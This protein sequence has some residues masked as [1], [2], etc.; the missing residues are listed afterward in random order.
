MF[1]KNTNL[2]TIPSFCVIVSIKEYG[3]TE[4]KPHSLIMKMPNLTKTQA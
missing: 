2:V 4:R 1:K 3:I